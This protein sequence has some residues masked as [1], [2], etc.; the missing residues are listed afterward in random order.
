M[1]RKQT[2]LRPYFENMPDIGKQ[3]SEGEVRRSTENVDL[4]REQE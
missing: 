4:I 1:S 3:L 2:P